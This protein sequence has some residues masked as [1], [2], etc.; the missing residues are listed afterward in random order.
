MVHIS[1]HSLLEGEKLISLNIHVIISVIKQHMQWAYCATFPDIQVAVC[2]YMNIVIKK[3][4]G[5]LHV[6]FFISAGNEL[7]ESM[8]LWMQH[9]DILIR[10]KVSRIFIAQ[11]LISSDDLHNYNFVN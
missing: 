8:E 10:L 2:T 4:E 5:W 6:F 3:P 11:I 1:F 9:S 7:Y